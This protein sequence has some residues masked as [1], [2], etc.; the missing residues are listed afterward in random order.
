[1]M[2]SIELITECRSSLVERFSVWIFA[3]HYL[4]YIGSFVLISSLN[5]GPELFTANF[6]S[7][8]VLD[9]M[10]MLF[11]TWFFRGQNFIFK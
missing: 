8:A 11:R 2:A 10:A 6:F 4:N 3:T 1:M 7:I 9:W 5:R